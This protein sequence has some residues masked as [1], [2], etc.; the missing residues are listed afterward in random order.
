MRAFLMVLVLLGAG[1]AGYFGLSGESGGASLKHE[2]LVGEIYGWGESARRRPVSFTD[3]GVPAPETPLREYEQSEELRQAFL[4]VA[5]GLLGLT[6]LCALL[7]SRLSNLGE[8]GTKIRRHLGIIALCAAVA[9]LYLDVYPGTWS[10]LAGIE[11]RLKSFVNNGNDDLKPPEKINL[12]RRVQAEQRRLMAF[13]AS[14]AFTG[15][16]LFWTVRL[17]RQS[18]PLEDED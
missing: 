10:Q 5:L 16:A 13:Y 8:A 6:G 15:V 18:A 1:S 11:Q 17:G 9:V 7:V 14:L 2:Y 12:L 3:E 4:S